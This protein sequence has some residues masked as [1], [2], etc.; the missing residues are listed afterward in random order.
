MNELVKLA[1]DLYNGRTY[2][3][4]STDAM[5]EALREKLIAV[6]GGKSTFTYREFRRHENEVFAIVEQAIDIILG[7]QLYDQFDDFVEIQTIAEGDIFRFHVD[8]EDL[9]PVA[10]I[11]DAN[12]SIRRRRLDQGDFMIDTVWRGVA[13]Y[14]EI[15]RYLQGR[16][17]WSDL[18]N[19][20]ARSYSLHIATAIYTA[21]YNSYTNLST[22]YAVSGAFT[23]DALATLVQH[24][25]AATNSEAVILGTKFALG[26]IAPAQVS[27][28]MIDKKNELGHYGVFRGTEMR[29]IKQFHKYNSDVFA[30]D[31]NFLMVIPK[32][33]EKIVKMVLEGEGRIE[34]TKSQKDETMDYMFKKKSGIGLLFAR[35]YGIYR[36]A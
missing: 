23:E 12:N 27:Q 33:G 29:E 13:V 1:V 24:V 28:N 26:K 25:E 30:I 4:Y 17:N 18:V 3:M 35:K 10:I 2:D 21:I 20:V 22:T 36:M 9:F 7:Q 14:E 15:Q 19:R 11:S 16:A 32:G 6:N 5:E 31:D 8:Q 34:E